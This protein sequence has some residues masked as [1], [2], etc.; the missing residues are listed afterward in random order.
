MPHLLLAAALLFTALPWA[1]AQAQA[2]RSFCDGA[3]RVDAT[4]QPG[5][6][7]RYDLAFDYTGTSP[8]RRP[9][10]TVT[11]DIPS[12]LFPN[13][14]VQRVPVFSI[15]RGERREWRMASESLPPDRR[16]P[17]IIAADVLNYVTIACAG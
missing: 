2:R 14:T 17:S 1:G 5:N 12:E 11:L 6:P 7:A 8:E 13:I 15:G 3:I 16:S 10:V 9:T 4:L